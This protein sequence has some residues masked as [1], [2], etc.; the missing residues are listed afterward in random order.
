MVSAVSVGQGAVSM[1]WA[2]S[3]RD[4]CGVAKVN[5]VLEK[6][7]HVHL[8]RFFIKANPD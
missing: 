1:D 8:T 6:V 4:P 3:Q 5:N 2:E 7:L